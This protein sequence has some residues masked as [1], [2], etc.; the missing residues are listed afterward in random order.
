MIGVTR[1]SLLVRALME[2]ALDLAIN[3]MSEVDKLYRMLAEGMVVP[4]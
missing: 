3:L 1:Y 4:E 2:S